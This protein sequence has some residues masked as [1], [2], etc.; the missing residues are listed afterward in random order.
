MKERLYIPH[1]IVVKYKYKNP[2]STEDAYMFI[3]D[4]KIG[5]DDELDIICNAVYVLPIEFGRVTEVTEEEDDY[6]EKEK[7]DHKHMCYHI[8]RYG[9]MEEEDVIFKK[10]DEEMKRHL[11]PLLIW[12]KVD[13][14]IKRQ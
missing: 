13:E 11:K 2:I 3:D 8:M 6:L 4:F 10:L 1:P 7:I 12:A 14:E 9:S 5:F